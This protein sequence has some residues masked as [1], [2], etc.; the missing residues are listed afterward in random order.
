MKKFSLILLAI[1]VLTF[2]SYAQTPQKIGYVDSQI[3]LTQLPE[4]IKAQGDLDALTNLW[5]A[6]VDSMTLKYQQS[7][8]D[9]QKQ[10]NTMAEDKKLAAQQTLIK[11]EQDILE[12]RRQ[13]FGQGS[14]EIYLK[15]EEIFTPVK[16]KIY[17]AIQQVAKDEGMQF[18][19]DKSGDI[20]L[21][22]ADAAFDVTYKVLDKLKRGN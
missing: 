12:F 17:T 3:I 18:V 7:L 22:Y 6:Q 20:I 2:S 13:K 9:Y 16:N 8:A 4:A 5:S 15:Q 21:L 11:M 14:G 1:V 19:F 10:A